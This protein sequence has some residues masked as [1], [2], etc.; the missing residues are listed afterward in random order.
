MLIRAAALSKDIGLYS[1]FSGIVVDG[2]Y[3]DVEEVDVFIREWKGNVNSLCSDNRRI[4][5]ASRLRVRLADSSDVKESFESEDHSFRARP[6]TARCVDYKPS[7]NDF[8]SNHAA[9]VP[10]ES[11]LPRSYQVWRRSID[12]ELLRKSI[13]DNRPRTSRYV[14]AGI[15]CGLPL[16]VF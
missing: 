11:C 3:T 5:H 1:E 6:A 7:L 2:F 10:S 16:K 8:A 4:L 14:L 12:S 13:F 15:L 9:F